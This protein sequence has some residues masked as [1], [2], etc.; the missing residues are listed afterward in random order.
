MRLNVDA[1]AV[2]LLATTLCQCG[3][4][5]QY[6]LRLY[7]LKEHD[8][9]EKADIVVVGITETV[10]R[11]SRSIPIRWDRQYGVA[12]ARLA[13][14]R[15]TV[16]EVIHGQVTGGSIVV[17]Y[18]AADQFTN[19]HSLSL[20]ELSVG[21]RAIH[22]IVNAPEGLRYV[23]DIV[24]STTPVHSG[25]HRPPAPA[26][27]TDEKTR[28]AQILLTPGDGMDRERFTAN[29]GSST[30]DALFLTGYQYTL[31]PLKALAQNPNL[32]LR[33]DACVQLYKSAFFG[34]DECLNHSSNGGSHP[35]HSS[36]LGGL[37]AQR[38][39]TQLRFK[40]SFMADPIR[41]AEEWA[42]LPPPEGKWDFLNLIAKHPDQK[43]AK[44]ARRALVASGHE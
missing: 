36:E 30:S 29:L 33:W 5:A 34:Q 25:A 3:S 9:M 20:P 6:P 38:A 26:G 40:T 31:P 27:S 23:A 44:R 12:S 10:Q 18:W 21:R 2:V 41:T 22:Y 24:S 28:L 14:V 11:G 19:A 35:K 42:V 17:R 15:I 32:N 8:L 7:D 16:E 37:L 43:L 4:E 39:R 1:V 13:S